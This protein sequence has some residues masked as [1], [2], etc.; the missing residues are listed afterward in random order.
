LRV[1]LHRS[2]M[3]CESSTTNTLRLIGWTL[4]VWSAWRRAR[5]EPGE[6]DE[7]LD[8]G[9]NTGQDQLSPSAFE[10]SFEAEQHLYDGA[11][12]VLGRR[13]I[14]AHRLA[15]G[16]GRGDG[17]IKDRAGLAQGGS[18]LD[19]DPCV[20]AVVGRPVFQCPVLCNRNLGQSARW[21]Q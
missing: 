13:A 2:R 6:L 3:V 10:V 4:L 8:R 14:D 9:R 7:A 15:R 5:A 20:E 1:R 19:R 12:E 11:V 17:S 18:T 16:R 21:G